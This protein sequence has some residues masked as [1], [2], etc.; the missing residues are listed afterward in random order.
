METTAQNVVT[1]FEGADT[2]Q[3]PGSMT[4][5]ASPD[6]AALFAGADVGLALFS[7]DLELL[8]C[9]S[10]YQTLCGYHAGEAVSG[11]S[12]RKLMRLTLERQ[13]TLAAA[14]DRTIETAVQRLTPGTGVTFRYQAPTGRT[15]EV[16]RQ[17]LESGTVV[18]TVR[19]VCGA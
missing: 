6:L 13:G 15:V 11:T 16:R 19:Q 2:G 4:P 5:I 10:L 1:L 18:E 14:I 8:A 3:Q 7:A 12:L 9:N 17:R